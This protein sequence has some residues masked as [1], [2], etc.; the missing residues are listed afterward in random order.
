MAWAVPERR[1]AVTQIWRGPL[2]KR[3]ALVGGFEDSAMVWG[4]RAARAELRIDG[5]RVGALRLK[6]LPGTQLAVI[7]T[8][9]YA[10]GE[11]DLEI[12]VSTRDAVARTVCIDGW[13]LAQ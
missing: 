11:H 1:K 7:D 5:A 12:S 3:L 2:G 9:R 13:V 4:R 6:N 10:A 8:A